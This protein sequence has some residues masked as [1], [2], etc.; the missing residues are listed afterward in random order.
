MA[1]NIPKINATLDDN[2]DEY[3][4]T[5]IECQGKISNHYV[6]I[7]IDPGASLSHVSLKI[8]ELCHFQM[9]K[10]KNHL[11][12]KLANGA[13]RMVAAKIGNYLVDITRQ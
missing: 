13:K 1:N 2:H 12:V 11:L 8:V 10:F 6:S 5:I 4:H 9:I 3:K 7:L